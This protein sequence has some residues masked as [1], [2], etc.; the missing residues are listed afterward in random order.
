MA[1][2]EGVDLGLVPLGARS[3][4]LAPGNEDGP[5]RARQG[6]DQDPRHV[7]EGLHGDSIQDRRP[8]W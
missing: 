3:A 8:P 4:D 2:C 6:S 1:V 7:V 5:V